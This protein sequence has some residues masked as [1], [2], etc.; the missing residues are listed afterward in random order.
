MII[1]MNATVCAAMNHGESRL[2]KIAGSDQC[3]RV[4]GAQDRA[5]GQGKQEFSKPSSTAVPPGNE[6]QAIYSPPA[7]I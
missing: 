6:V 5:S 7:M 2:D 3:R 1:Q 4:Q